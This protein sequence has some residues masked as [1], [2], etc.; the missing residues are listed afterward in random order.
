MRQRSSIRW[1]VRAEETGPCVTLAWY[2]MRGQWSDIWCIGSRNKD[3]AVPC[4]LCGYAPARCSAPAPGATRATQFIDGIVVLKPY[5]GGREQKRVGHRA[6]A[7]L[8]SRVHT[9]YSKACAV[10]ARPTCAQNL[11]PGP[12]HPP[13]AKDQAKAEAGRTTPSP[14]GR[15]ATVPFAP[16]TA[17]SPRTKNSSVHHMWLIGLKTSILADRVLEENALFNLR[18]DLVHSWVCPKVCRNPITFFLHV[19]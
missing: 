5:Q 15:R 16:S 13:H 10:R 17:L 2:R 1:D 7:L 12:R 4:A 3:Q 19:P 8:S 9:L 6:R 18:P 11:I 14:A